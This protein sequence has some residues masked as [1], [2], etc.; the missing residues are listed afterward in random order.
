MRKDEELM[1]D[2]AHGDIEA[3]GE[4]VRRNQRYAWNTAWRMLQDPAEAEDVA[5][6]AFLRVLDAA[7]R[8][9]PTAAFRTYLCRVVTRLCLDRLEKKKPV[10]TDAP[11][12]STP[13]GVTPSDELI[14]RDRASAVNRA[15]QALPP[16]QRAALM[17]RYFEDLNYKQIAEILGASV[18]SVERLLARGREALADGLGEWRRT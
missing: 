10:Y 11:P 2:V 1:Q 6:D 7:S 5:Q 3:F 9:R 4:L 16:R 14:S 8:Y 13:S 17:L 18:K 15:L 12:A